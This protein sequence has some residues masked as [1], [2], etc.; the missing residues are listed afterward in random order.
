MSLLLNHPHVLH[1]AYTEIEA[2]VGTNRLLDKTDLPNLS[3]L[4]NIITETFRLFPPVPLLL[5][6]K[7]STDCTVSGFHVPRGTMLLVNTWSMNKDPRLWEEPDKFIPERFEGSESMEEYNYKL[8]PFG[9]GRRACP[10]AGMAKRMVGLTLGSL[11][12]CFE[13]ERIG[14]EDIDLREGNGLTMPKAVALEAICKPRKNMID[15]LSAL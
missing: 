6:H 10:G 3:Y 1:K 14:E 13:W 4:Q 12:Q 9:A 7:S 5:P 11:I 2:V 8:L 15:L